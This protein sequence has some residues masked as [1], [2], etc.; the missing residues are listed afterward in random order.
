MDY[1]SVKQR[2]KTREKELVQRI[3]R[4]K[5]NMQ[6]SA[7][8]DWSEQAQERENDE[9]MEAL[10]HEAVQELRQVKQAIQ[11]IEEDE[12]GICERCGQTIPEARLEVMPYTA[13]CIRC[14]DQKQALSR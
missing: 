7:N 11:R 5:Q 13:R 8:K 4:I 14:A 6:K 9:V 10:G 1:H 3:E 2:L 12:Y